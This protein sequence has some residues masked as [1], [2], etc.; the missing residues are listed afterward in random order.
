MRVD[1]G[2]LPTSGRLKGSLRGT[3]PELPWF[4]RE[5]LVTG[6]AKQ[7]VFARSLVLP[8]KRSLI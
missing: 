4:I 8:L 5:A 7:P 2:L 6:M 1:A 3:A